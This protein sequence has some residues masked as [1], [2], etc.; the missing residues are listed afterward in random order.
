VIP[1]MSGGYTDSRWLRSVG[2]PGLWR[3]GP[4]QRTWANNGV[5]GL[6]EQVGVQQLYD[7]RL[8]LY[9]LVKLLAKKERGAR[10]GASS[11]RAHAAQPRRSDRPPSG[12]PHERETGRSRPPRDA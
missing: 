9:R 1:T 12:R 10:L 6:N 7:S 3:V 8:F 4:V 11:A 5:H 2:I